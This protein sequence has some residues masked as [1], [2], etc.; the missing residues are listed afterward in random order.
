MNHNEDIPKI[1]QDDCRDKKTTARGV[2]G[3]ALRLRKHETVH[4]PTDNLKGFERRLVTAPGAIKFTTIKEMLIM[5]WLDRIKNGEIPSLEIINQLAED[6]GN[7]VAQAI[8]VEL[9]RTRTLSELSKTIKQFKIHEK[10]KQTCIKYKVAKDR[11]GQ[12]FTGEKALE[13]FENTKSKT[14]TN[15]QKIVDSTYTNN[16]LQPSTSEQVESIAQPILYVPKEE[17]PF[18]YHKKTY[19]TKQIND[20]LTRLGLFLDPDCT[21]EIEIKIK[22]VD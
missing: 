10:Y 21:Y 16:K 8:L 22:E 15:I 12:V 19:N 5:D 2:H 6:E 7:E 4:M 18:I 17:T 9:L 1:F 13:Y 3:R 20:F 14:N 11:T